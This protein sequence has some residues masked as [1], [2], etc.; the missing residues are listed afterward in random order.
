MLFPPLIEADS[1]TALRFGDR[2]LS[3][4]RVRDAAAAVAER[5]ARLRRVAVW[6]A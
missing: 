1:R 2:E 4:G 3:Y 5:V 6:G